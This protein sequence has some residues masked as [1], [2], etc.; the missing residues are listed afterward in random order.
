VLTPNLDGSLSG[1]RRAVLD[2][3]VPLNAPRLQGHVSCRGIDG[4]F[5]WG[6]GAVGSLVFERPLVDALSV[7]IRPNLVTYRL[8]GGSVSVAALP[9]RPAI[10]IA[11]EG[12]AGAVRFA[13][14]RRRQPGFPTGFTMR[15]RDDGWDAVS[16]W[17]AARLVACGGT[18]TQRGGLGVPAGTAA[19]L[20]LGAD[21]AEASTAAAAITRDLAGAVRSARDH[22]ARLQ[23]TFTSADPV[24]N[25]LFTAC[26]HAAVSSRKELA[27]GS[28]AGYSAGTGY[29]MPPRT[30][31]RDSYWT[32]QALLPFAPAE[33]LAQLRLL[34]SAV[35][36]DGEAPSGVIVA[37]DAGER[38]WQARLAADPGLAADHPRAGQWWS[39]H[40]D[41]PYYLVLLARDALTWA[42]T[43]SGPTKGSGPTKRSGPIKR[44]GRDTG[45]AWHEELHEPVGGVVLLDRIRAVLERGRRLAGGG[46]L[47]VK[48]DHDRDWADNVYRHGHVTY[49]V[50]LYHGALEA[51]AE[52]LAGA[53][54]DETAVYRARAAAV[55]RAAGEL[56]FDRE[57]GHF[58]EYRPDGDP[59]SGAGESHLTLDSLVALRAGMA[60]AAQARS[61]LDAAARV[62]ETGAN[63]EQP[64]GD[65]GVMCAYPPYRPTTRRRGKSLFAYRYHNGSDWPYLDGV[66]AEALLA[67]GMPGWRYPLT[68]WF[69]YGLER[70]WPT[71]VEYYSPPWG[72][73]SPLNGW[74]AMP[75]A[76]MLL[77]GFGLSPSGTPRVP[78]WEDSSVNG[79]QVN[80]ACR[81]VTSTQGRVELSE[82]DAHG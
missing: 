20:A 76:A 4:L 73:G 56:L 19:V 40:F 45:P 2:V 55:R 52:L 72:R 33:A 10:V 69:E 54:P 74:S 31:F 3:S 32:L 12:V 16:P 15:T 41:S 51:G 49:D 39:D 34:A 59:G 22:A 14:T 42:T 48:P 7:E 53:Y 60:S 37:S 1:G 30:Y 5:V 27:D 81:T 25:S 77:G 65:W 63:H 44:S 78:P 75:A 29:V 35:G 38:V 8:P 24:L 11:F 79:V 21:V 9:D 36:E 47:P 17:A 62:L 58:V 57:R 61:S 70:G 23:R 50:A 82:G 64:Y 46:V 18:M 26:L 28:F 43:R 68:R 71:P 13:P 80:G 67:R 66:Y 6:S